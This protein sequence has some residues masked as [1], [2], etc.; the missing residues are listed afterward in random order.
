MC[1]ARDKNRPA[2]VRLLFVQEMRRGS[3]G[4]R[5]QACVFGGITEVLD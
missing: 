5:G 1:R 4:V 2:P 3:S